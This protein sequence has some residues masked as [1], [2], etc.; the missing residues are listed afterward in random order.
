MKATHFSMWTLVAALSCAVVIPVHAYNGGQ[1]GDCQQGPSSGMSQ[2]RMK[3][4]EQHQ[5]ALKANLKLAPEQE[6]AWQA[7]VQAM[8]PP[9]KP[10]RPNPAE[11]EA[12]TTPQ[13]LEKMKAMKAERDAHMNQRIQAIQTFYGVLTPE[14]QK[15]FD[16]HKPM[17]RH[18][19]HGEGHRMKG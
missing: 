11:L 18:S 1:K 14:Q 4:M 15:V 13:R 7:F 2:Q 16:A 19:H 9:A 8:K 3:K 5:A 10:E 6:A 12:M 17:R